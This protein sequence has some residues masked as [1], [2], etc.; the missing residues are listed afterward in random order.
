MSTTERLSFAS[1]VAADHIQALLE[2][3]HSLDID[4]TAL[5]RQCK[6]SFDLAHLKDA[7]VSGLPLHQ[8]VKLRQIC[9]VAIRAKLAS[10]QRPA[11]QF[12]EFQLMC[13]AVI[14]STVLNEA[15][16]RILT[17]STMAA[18]R[19]G[20]AGLSVEG[21]EACFQIGLGPLEQCWEEFFSVNALMLFSGLFGWLIG[22]PLRC[23]YMVRHHATRESD[24]L[25]STFNI[26]PRHDASAN[27]ILFP[28]CQLKLPIVR[29]NVQLH[30]FLKGFPDN[31]I[32]TESVEADLGE[33]IAAIYRSALHRGQHVPTT[34]ELAR[35]LGVS[36]ATLRR[37]LVHENGAFQDIKDQVR[38]EIA[39]EFL[40]TGQA[41]IDRIAYQLDY[42]SSRAFARAFQRCTGLSPTMF[43]KRATSG[44]TT[45]A[46]Q[47]R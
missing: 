23:T 30:D 14:S 12:H 20:S 43:R 21:D 18:D 47:T 34:G 45:P 13:H 2:K 5:L 38:T 10:P 15:I 11:M 35:A 25:S 3:A 46:A 26:R 16:E 27:A 29:S 44:K 40:A 42:S 28:A 17:F 6:L 31:L 37:R 1:H 24:A 32:V 8:F 39:Q 33:R 7:S 9:I 41:S 36:E 4:T 22:E 19:F